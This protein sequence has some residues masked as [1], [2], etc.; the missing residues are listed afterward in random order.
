MSLLTKSALL[1]KRFYD[2]QMKLLK[3]DKEIERQVNKTLDAAA[4]AQSAIIKKRPKKEIEQKTKEL[5]DAAR[6]L[7]NGF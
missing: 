7:I 3:K 2:Y 4:Q 5:I 1:T 6:I